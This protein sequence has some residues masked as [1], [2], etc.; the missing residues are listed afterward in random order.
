MSILVKIIGFFKNSYFV[1]LAFIIAQIGEAYY[2]KL[3]GEAIFWIITG[4]ISGIKY[5]KKREAKEL[6]DTYLAEREFKDY[7]LLNIEQKENGL[8]KATCMVLDYE[9]YYNDLHFDIELDIWS[10]RYSDNFTEK[11]QEHFLEY[12][13][14][15][16]QLEAL[17]VIQEDEINELCH[18]ENNGPQ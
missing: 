8:W 6:I 17:S 18:R 7:K 1:I 14:R 15:E 4:I 2:G 11:E 16:K 3:Y 10:G 9:K 12:T 13:D 5:L